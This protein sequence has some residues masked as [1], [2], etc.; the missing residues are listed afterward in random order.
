MFWL[1]K[2]KRDTAIA[3]T[4]S[5]IFAFFTSY[6][7]ALK[8]IGALEWDD[9]II[10]FIN[11]VIIAMIV[12]EGYLRLKGWIVQNKVHVNDGYNNSGG[13]K[14]FLGCAIV[15]LTLWIPVFC[16]YYPGIFS[17]D[18]AGQISQATE[19]YNTHHPLLHTLYILFFY[20]LVG[21]KLL[22]NYT[23]GIAMA[24]VTQMTVFSMMISYVHLYLYRC[25]FHRTT[26]YVLVG[27]SALLPY[28]SLL[29]IS[30]TKDVLFAGF[31]AVFV[32]CL[33]YW[34]KV[35]DYFNK[36]FRIVLYISSVMGVILF[37]NNGIYGIAV[38][39][40]ICGV[41]AFYRKSNYRQF[42]FT[43][44]GLV[45]GVLI[46]SGL[47]AGLQ[48]QS[49]S[50]NEILSLPYQQ[51]SC[52]YHNKYDE[53][54]KEEVSEIENWIPTVE[55]YNPYCADGV[56]GVARG[57][58]HLREFIKFYIKLG[59]KFPASYIRGGIQNNLGY[60]YLWD[61]SHSKIYGNDLEGRQ[62]YLLTDTKQGFGV[63]H[64]SQFPALENIYEILYTTNKYQNILILDLLC[65]PAFYFWG[66]V[67]FCFYAVDLGWRIIKLP[68]LFIAVY[69][70]TLFAGPCVLIR[71]AL[72]YIICLPVLF[73]CTFT[74][75]KVKILE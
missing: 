40:G 72:P 66:I 25:G 60:L 69:M 3:L 21:H 13:R 34:E 42:V 51:I 37:R 15:I 7:W 49:G 56:K 30:M 75:N 14:Y 8:N 10:I 23:V 9:R 62:G 58:N 55:H 39:T 6:G 44:A 18:V 52:V 1:F 27:M 33:C 54:A 22:H 65:S 17:Y 12:G 35:P 11:I 57:K 29:A 50:L 4:F 68:L 46:N 70:M 2:D 16:A 31:V 48:A 36:K 59:I 20:T 38:V 74:W 64:R 67:L 53:L 32:T 43:F 24:S 61:V 5:L 71:Y 63:D 73:D 19:G 26:R 47:K 45:M 28:F 41:L